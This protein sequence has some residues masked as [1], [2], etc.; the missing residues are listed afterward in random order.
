[1]YSTIHMR[2]IFLLTWPQLLLVEH[3]IAQI[4]TDIITE[5]CST[6]ASYGRQKIN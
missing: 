6:N 2:L 1:M 5:K 3:A 4:E